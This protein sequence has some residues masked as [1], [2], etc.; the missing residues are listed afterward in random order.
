MDH[1]NTPKRGHETL[2][3]DAQSASLKSGFARWPATETVHATVISISKRLGPQSGYPSLDEQRCLGPLLWNIVI[4]LRTERSGFAIVRKLNGTFMKSKV[5]HINIHRAKIFHSANTQP[6]IKSICVVK[7][8]HI[9]DFVMALPAFQALRSEFPSAAIDLV[10]ARWNVASAQTCG[11]FREIHVFDFFRENPSKPDSSS[12]ES[13]PLEIAK[14]QYDLAIDL[15][16]QEDTRSVLGKISA[17]WHAGI[18]SVSSDSANIIVLPRQPTDA[19][20]F[21]FHQQQFLPI[22]RA[23]RCQPGSLVDKDTLIRFTAYE[24]HKNLIVVGPLTLTGGTYRAMLLCSFHAKFNVRRPIVIVGAFVDG[25]LAVERRLTIARNRD[26]CSVEF[27]VERDHSPVDLRLRIRRGRFVKIE[28][29]GAL[30]H[31]TPGDRTR[32]GV[33]CHQSSSVL[34]ARLRLHITE[35]LLLLVKLAACRLNGVS[36]PSNVHPANIDDRQLTIVLAPFSNSTIR[37]WPIEH[38]EELIGKM[39]DFYGGEIVLLGSATQ[40][41]ALQKLKSKLHA[42]GIQPVIVEA[43]MPMAEVSTRLARASLI[44]ANN[45]GIAHLAGALGRPVVAIYS[46]SH[47]VDEWGAVGTNVSLIQAEIECQRCSLDFNE[48]CYNDHRCMRD[49]PPDV[50]F[51]HIKGNVAWKG[52][53]SA[54]S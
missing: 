37:D 8:D 52:N 19:T 39:H 47:D 31:E 42:A 2:W 33:V 43:G 36:F 34:A 26:S 53:C 40:V 1:V 14:R 27:S 38:Y 30:I 13:L 4:E 16:A 12:S 9:G 18:G 20:N 46:A 35:Q 54:R 45:S 10:C 29:A 25:R 7:V 6:E 44:I 15:R 51:S 28:F 5:S 3:I 32:E 23:T 49:L 48:N 41:A 50:V 22:E 21:E 24:K 17:R 11:L